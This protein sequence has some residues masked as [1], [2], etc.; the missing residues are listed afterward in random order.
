MRLREIE[1]EVETCIQ[2]SKANFPWC[3]KLAVTRLEKILPALSAA[4]KREEDSIAF[5]ERIESRARNIG[6][7][8]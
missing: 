1:D 8:L 5:D 3:S 2:L 7:Y 6:A 4:A